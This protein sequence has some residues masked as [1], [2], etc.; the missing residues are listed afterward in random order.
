MTGVG[1]CGE[2]AMSTSTFLNSLGINSREV[3]FPGEDHTFVEVMLNGTW[4][5]IDPG[6]YHGQILKR[7]QRGDYRLTEMGAVSY[8]IADVNSSFVELTQSYV[9]TDTIK[10]KVVNANEP[11]LDAQV[12]LEHT[13]MGQT[14][15]LPDA[16]HVFYSDTN[17]T[18]TLHMGSLNYTSVAGKV[19][20][21]YKVYVNGKLTPY[22]VTSTGSN[23]TQY[24][25]IDL[26]KLK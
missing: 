17:G 19:D 20:S 3:N 24:V 1:A 8:V 16:T 12:Y 10:I 21:F 4:F 14:W 22:T 5:V 15:R 9:P 25:E 7:E 26:A 23:K 13:F 2:L 18:V 11:V 6:Y